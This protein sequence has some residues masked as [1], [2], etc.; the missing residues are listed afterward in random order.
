MTYSI[1][2]AS[3]SCARRH[4]LGCSEE[5]RVNKQPPLTAR[6]SIGN[7]GPGLK[8]SILPG[9]E[10][11]GLIL[12]LGGRQPGVLPSTAAHGSRQTSSA[13]GFSTDSCC[14]QQ[15]QCL[16]CWTE[17]LPACVGSQGDVISKG[18]VLLGLSASALSGYLGRRECRTDTLP[19]TLA[20]KQVCQ[21]CPSS[22]SHERSPSSQCSHPPLFREL[23]CRTC[24]TW[25]HLLKGSDSNV[26]TLFSRAFSS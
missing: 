7:K 9:H 19:G 2:K 8:E 20:H 1:I 5:E 12:S 10:A 14:F 11:A 23:F 17:M 22:M 24:I 13:Q 21:G 6:M 4:F 3:L 25:R 16:T 26:N 18:K 15:P